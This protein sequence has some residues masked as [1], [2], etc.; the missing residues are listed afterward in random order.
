MIWTTRRQHAACRRCQHTSVLLKALHPPCPV[1]M[2][3]RTPAGGDERPTQI[4]EFDAFIN[5]ELD[6]AYVYPS[7]GGKPAEW[8]TRVQ[9]ARRRVALV[10]IAAVR[11]QKVRPRAATAAAP[12]PICFRTTSTHNTQS[13]ACSRAA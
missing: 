4:T 7:L 8:R 12:A 2:H 10:V 5:A 3:A 11:W 9:A 6:P 1:R 13:L